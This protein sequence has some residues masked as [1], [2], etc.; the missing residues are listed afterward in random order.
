MKGFAVTL[1]IGMVVGSY[2]TIYIAAPITEWMDKK[3]FSRA[4]IERPSRA[5]A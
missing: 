4:P 2:S 5:S 1:V 3:L